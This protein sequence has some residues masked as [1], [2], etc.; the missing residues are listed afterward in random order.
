MSNRNLVVRFD[1]IIV[2]QDLAFHKHVVVQIHGILNPNQLFRK[3]K[4]WI[5]LP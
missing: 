1:F 2:N 3:K 4:S 5:P